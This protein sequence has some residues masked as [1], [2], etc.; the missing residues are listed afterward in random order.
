MP[1]RSRS[2]TTVGDAFIGMDAAGLVTD[3]DGPG[4]GPGPVHGRIE[5][6]PRCTGS[7][8]RQRFVPPLTHCNKSPA[9]LLLSVTLRD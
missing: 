6:M 2:W 1:G 7:K 3:L 4:S 5:P 8:A 9:G